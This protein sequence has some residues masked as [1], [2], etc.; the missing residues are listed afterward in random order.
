MVLELGQIHV[1]P[2][3]LA[4]IYLTWEFWHECNDLENLLRNSR[5]KVVY[6]PSQ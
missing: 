4:D 2:A 3:V 6:V 1:L 5:K